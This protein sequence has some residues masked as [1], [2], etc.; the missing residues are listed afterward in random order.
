MKKSPTTGLILQ[1]RID[2]SRLPRK[3]LLDLGGKP[4]VFRVMEALL[5]VPVEYHILACPADAAEAFRPLAEEAGFHL[6]VGDKENVLS[7]YVE[8]ARSFHLDTVV[9]ATGDNPFVF[10]DGATRLLLETIRCGADYGAYGG[11][12]YGAGVEVVR[13][14]ALERAFWEAETAY[15][16]EHVCPYLYTHPESFYL[17]RPLAPRLWRDPR[18]RLTV[19]TLAD[20]ERARLL[21]EAL[22]QD[23]LVQQ[24]PELRYTGKVIR[25]VARFLDSGD[26]SAGKFSL[27]DVSVQGAC[28]NGGKPF[29]KVGSASELPGGQRSG[30]LDKPVVPPSVGQRGAV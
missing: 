29:K 8:A 20:Y 17:H 28:E 25:R 27:S 12:P 10:S 1:A 5:Y 13:R 3:A 18:L 7:R 23:P 15:D 19:D 22:S 9:R 21:Y 2:S 16:R 24:K 11:L 6:F 14:E 4:L 30:G 26:S